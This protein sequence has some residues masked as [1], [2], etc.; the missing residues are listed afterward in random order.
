MN[1]IINHMLFDSIQLSA[2]FHSK[3]SSF[4]AA[5]HQALVLGAAGKHVYGAGRQLGLI[6]S[7]QVIW[8][9]RPFN[10]S[11]QLSEWITSHIKWKQSYILHCMIL[12]FNWSIQFIKN[13]VIFLLNAL[14]ALA[15]RMEASGQ[16]VLRPAQALGL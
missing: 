10:H 13:R 16:G 7:L 14:A 8:I 2:L 11:I 12:H 5:P 3:L 9:Q 6:S 15:P 1:S 4:N